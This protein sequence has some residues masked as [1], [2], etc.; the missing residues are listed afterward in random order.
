MEAMAG[1]VAAVLLVSAGLF[2]SAA[3]AQNDAPPP[4]QGQ[5]QG[6]PPGGPRGPMEDPARRTMR[7]QKQLGLSD[8]QTAQVKTVLADSGAKMETLRANQDLDPRDRRTQMMALRK[9]EET[10]LEAIFTPDQKAKYEEMMAQ[11]RARMQN[12][13]GGPGGP[14]PPP[15]SR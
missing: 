3:V 7:L 4:P 14:P 12:R 15:P 13:G 11:E 1:R 9:D 5:M 2:V 8:E 10:R 6:P